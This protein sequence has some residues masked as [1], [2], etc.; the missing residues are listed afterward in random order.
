MINT[1]RNREFNLA[2]DNVKEAITFIQY[3]PGNMLIV[4]VSQGVMVDGQFR[5]NEFSSPESYMIDGE[6][7]SAMLS[8]TDVE[9]A[10]SAIL[11]KCWDQID[12]KRGSNVN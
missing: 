1:S 4:Q 10:I 3:E 2:T 9:N 6:Q 12:L 8:D 5:P 7:L 11:V